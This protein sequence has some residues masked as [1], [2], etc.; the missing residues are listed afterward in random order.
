LLV[1]LLLPVLPVA[2]DATASHR[3]ATTDDLDR[4]GLDRSSQTA[5]VA[6]S[7]VL[8]NDLLVSDAVD[9]RDRLLEDL[10]CGCLVAS[11]DGFADGLDRGAQR[12]TLSRVVSV[13]L[14]CLTSALARLC[15]IC[16]GIS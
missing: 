14:D 4:Q 13:L 2:S 11:L 5:L 12:R 6:S 16:H 1:L 10:R 15:R 8:V 3:I 9:L 7:L